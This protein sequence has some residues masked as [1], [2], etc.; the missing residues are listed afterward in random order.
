MVL[1]YVLGGGV[2]KQLVYDDLCDLLDA[3]YTTRPFDVLKRL[4]TKWLT[5]SPSI[6]SLKSEAFNL[7]NIFN[8]N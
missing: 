4:E 8:H 6:P 1:Y 2:V 3:F 7:Q 5:E